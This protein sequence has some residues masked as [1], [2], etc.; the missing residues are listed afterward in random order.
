MFYRDERREYSYD[1]IDNHYGGDGSWSDPVK[2]THFALGVSIGHKY[3][4]NS[5]F[6]IQ[7]HFG[8]G[9]RLFSSSDHEYLIP[10]IGR[11]GISFGF[12]F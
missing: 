2:S 11:G 10:I 9:R 8:F 3:V 4:S 7:T 6:V 1:D 12:Q 5:G